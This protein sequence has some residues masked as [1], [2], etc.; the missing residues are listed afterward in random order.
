MHTTHFALDY[1]SLS[2]LK[3]GNKEEEDE[4]VRRSEDEAVNHHLLEDRDTRSTW[5]Q[6]L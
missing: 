3:Q 6:A 4:E 1:G 5:R 2:H